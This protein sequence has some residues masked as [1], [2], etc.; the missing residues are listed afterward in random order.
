VNITVP[1]TFIHFK[2]YFCQGLENN[3]FTSFEPYD[4]S[5]IVKTLYVYVLSKRV[6]VTPSSSSSSSSSAA[7][8]AT[9]VAAASRFR[10]DWPAPLS[11]ILTPLIS[12]HYLV[13]FWMP[14]SPSFE[15]VC[16]QIS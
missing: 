15:T 1:F 8:A 5:Y 7:A 4:I 14:L 16:F 12:S 13:P 3:L 2:G 11:F 9:T 6:C 10:P